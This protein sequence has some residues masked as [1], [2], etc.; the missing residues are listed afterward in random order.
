MYPPRVPAGCR[1]P[2]EQCA[3]RGAACSAGPGVFG[4]VCA[5]CGVLAVWPVCK[6]LFAVSIPEVRLSRGNRV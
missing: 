2:L 3:R 6:S 4:K 1:P 5:V